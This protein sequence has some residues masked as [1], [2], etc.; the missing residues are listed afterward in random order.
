MLFN[1]KKNKKYSY[2]E[3]GEGVPIVLLHGLMGELS[4]FSSLTHHFSQKGFKVY[5]P[6]LPIYSY[7][8]LNTN[9]SSIAKFVAKFIKDIVGEP[10][11]L[12]GNSLGGHL[13]LVTTL[14][15]PDLVRALCLTGSSG[16]YEKSF[17]ETFPKRGSY[18]YVL[19]KTQ[20]VFYD[21]N[22]ATKEIVD[23]VFETINDRKKAIK[24]LYIA[25]SAL[26][27]NMKND[28]KNIKT[29]VCL[30]WG[31]QDSVTPPE[32]AI[33]FE[34]ELPNANL[35]WIDKCGHAP[36]MEH[37]EVFNQLLEAWLKEQ[38]IAT[39]IIG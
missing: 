21:P 20:E 18:D 3:E 19:K 28:L 9:V 12:V 33:E 5:A 29:P 24:T 23:D 27:H 22:V 30:I 26:K 14:R 36:M 17:G 8:I 31:K 6:K 34:Q 16:L 38:K 35:Y 7:P 4:N 32:V 2:I 25:R 11:V 15:H 13:G 1:L 10:V 37:P 39:E